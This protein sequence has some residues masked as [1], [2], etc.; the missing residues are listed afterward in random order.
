MWHFA[1]SDDPNAGNS[2]ES[3]LPHCEAALSLLFDEQTA[4]ALPQSQQ[5]P[6]EAIHLQMHT[7]IIGVLYYT[8]VGNAK[9][10]SLRLSRLHL[11]LDA[12]PS[13]SDAT[14]YVKV[15]CHWS[16]TALE[17]IF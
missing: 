7:L 16:L 6:Q 15:N 3:L 13:G 4:A 1:P 17:H 8:L 2:V 5:L 14:A 9:A 11:L 12:N 10:S